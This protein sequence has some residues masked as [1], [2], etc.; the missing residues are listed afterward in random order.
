MTG[1][2]AEANGQSPIR[3][4]MPIEVISARLVGGLIPTRD[5]KTWHA[6]RMS[7]QEI[8]LNRASNFHV[9]IHSIE[10]PLQFGL[11][12][13]RI[14]VVSN[15]PGYHGRSEPAGRDHASIGEIDSWKSEWSGSREGIL[16]VRVK[17]NQEI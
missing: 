12:Q 1:G 3:Q 6:G 2:V 13:R 14:D 17:S 4:C 15:L 5:L 10:L 9:L 11:P 16:P 7:R 8:L